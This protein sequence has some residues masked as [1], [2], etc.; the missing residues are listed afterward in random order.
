MG[1][2]SQRGRDS[3]TGFYSEL[4]KS[5]MDAKRKAQVGNAYE[6]E[7]QSQKGFRTMP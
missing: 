7:Y 1:Q 5:L 2:L 4:V 3:H 6:A